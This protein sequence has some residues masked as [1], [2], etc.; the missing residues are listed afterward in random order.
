VDAPNASLQVR[1][2]IAR[3]RIFKSKNPNLG[4]FCRVLQWEWLVYFMSL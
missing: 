2:R 4:K 1:A 3:W